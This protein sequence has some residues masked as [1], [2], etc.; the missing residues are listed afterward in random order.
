[1]PSREPDALEL[2]LRKIE[3]LTADV[4]RLVADLKAAERRAMR[5]RRVAELIHLA[6]S[7][8]HSSDDT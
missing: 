1:M 7:R 3:A 8:D 2:A 6:N 5:Y 4:D